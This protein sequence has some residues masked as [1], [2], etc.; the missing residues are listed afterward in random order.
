MSIAKQLEK[1]ERITLQN[2]CTWKC[3]KQKLFEVTPPIMHSGV[4]CYAKDTL[5][6]YPVPS[7]GSESGLSY[8]SFPPIY[9]PNVL[10]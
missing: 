6:A 3:A 2:F 7:E 9:L 5:P 1:K 8:D 4:R 10:P